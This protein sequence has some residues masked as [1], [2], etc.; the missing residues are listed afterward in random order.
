MVHSEKIHFLEDKKLQ[1]NSC[2]DLPT[3][4]LKTMLVTLY[5]SAFCPRCYL[6]QKYILEI[7]AHD[8]KIQLKVVDVMTSPR[9]S[10]RSGIKMIPA[11]TIDHH[12]LSALF[13]S[14]TTI[15]DFIN[16]HKC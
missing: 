12:H 4:A 6:A 14:K 1:I 2:S 8:P 7:I 13:L 3:P 10:L 11:L 16:S 15:A 5:K 9:Q